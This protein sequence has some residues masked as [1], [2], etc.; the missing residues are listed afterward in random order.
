MWNVPGS[1][2]TWEKSWGTR[3]VF[4][5]PWLVETSHLNTGLH[6]ECLPHLDHISA[7]EVSVTMGW[8]RWFHLILSHASLADHELFLWETQSAASCSPG[9]TADCGKVKNCH[10]PKIFSLIFLSLPQ[11]IPLTSETFMKGSC[12][13]H[14]FIFLL[15]LLF[16]LAKDVHGGVLQPNFF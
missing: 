13:G 10:S 2:F 4:P 5:S 8:C 3:N 16:M 1:I 11:E 6:S 9:F 7:S 15:L 14:I 12:V